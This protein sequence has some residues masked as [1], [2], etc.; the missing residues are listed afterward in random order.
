MT[1]YEIMLSESQERMLLVVK[2]GREAEVERD[3]REVGP[4]RGAHRRG[5]R[6]RPAAREGPRHG[7]RR[8]SEHARS[9]TRRRSTTGRRRARPTSTR[10]SALDAG[11]AAAGAAPQDALLRAARVADRSPAS[12]GSTGS[13]TTWSARTRSCSPAWAPASCASRARRARSRCRSTATAATATSIRGAAR[14]SRSPKRRATSPA[15]ARMP[16]GATNCLNFGNPER[17]EIMWQFVEAVAGHRRGLPRARHAD[18][19]RQRQ[20]LQRD[21]RQG[22]LPDA[23][24]RRRR[25][26][27][28]TRRA[29]WR[30]R[31]AATGDDVVLLGESFGEL[32]GSEY[33]KTVH[34]LV[35][36]AAAGAR[37]GA[38][39][40]A[41]SRCSAAPR[42]PGC[43]ARRTTARTAA[44]RSRSPS[45]RSTPAASACDVDVPAA[46]RPARARCG[47]A[48]R[49][50]G[51]AR[52]RVG[53]AGRS[54]RAAAAGGRAP[55]CRRG[56][57]A[58]P[59]ARG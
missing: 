52:R 51:V 15:P 25:P 43:C 42:R 24:H 30:G 22:D 38:R 21:R 1:P 10:C 6:R 11:V 47:D 41:A 23:G 53:A 37:S 34:G 12:A 19:R 54:R 55:A 49:R 2:K 33:L 4:A 45:A 44:S 8:D 16:I 58:R 31:S 36:G 59:A 7:R 48:V 29:C 28:R 26:A 27:S 5:H 56:R 39:A 35:R 9:S 20:P 13:T 46:R 17:P 14:C 40:R 18:H 32:G 50:V 3:L 57:S